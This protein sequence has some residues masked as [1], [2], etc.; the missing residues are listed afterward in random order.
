M[1]ALDGTNHKTSRDLARGIARR[2]H[3]DQVDKVGEPYIGHVARVATEVRRA[4][5]GF[6]VQAVA[7]LH[8]VVEDTFVTL[9]DLRGVF[10]PE[11]VEAVDAI[12]K[13]PHEPFPAY[14]E[15][16][17]ANARATAVKWFDV[18]D[19]A[20]EDRLGRVAP[21]TQERLRAKYQRALAELRTSPHVSEV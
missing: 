9:E 21:D 19:N 17:K 15:R 6:D 8:D 11:V 13:R 10:P 5:F 16:V 4:G 14:Y 1:S 2:A 3:R 18:A 20:R 12:T 7:W